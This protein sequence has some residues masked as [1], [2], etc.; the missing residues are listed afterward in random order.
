MTPHQTP[1]PTWPKI[2]TSVLQANSEE[3]Y[4]DGS[5]HPYSLCPLQKMCSCDH[6]VTPQPKYI[7]PLR[8]GILLMKPPSFQLE[9]G[10]HRITQKTDRHPCDRPSMPTC[11]SGQ[12]KGQGKDTDKI[13]LEST[14]GKNKSFGRDTKE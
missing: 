3:G 12:S 10:S 9:S 6:S 2:G 8:N 7:S 11:R 4:M 1:E 13:N 5:R 14:H